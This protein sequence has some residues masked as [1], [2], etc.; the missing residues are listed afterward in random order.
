MLPDEPASIVA[1]VTSRSTPSETLSAIRAEYRDRF[2]RPEIQ[3]ALAA[4]K[5]SKQTLLRHLATSDDKA[6]RLALAK[7][8]NTP[9]D[10]LAELASDTQQG[11]RVAV[12]KNV[13]TPPDVLLVMATT[14]P[15][16]Q[17]A[18]ALA[19]NAS[20]ASTRDGQAALEDLTTDI[21]ARKPPKRASVKDRVESIFSSPHTPE[22]LNTFRS[23]G[24]A[25]VRWAAVIRGYELEIYPIAEVAELIRTTP[26]A[27]PLLEERWRETGD[28]RIADA[29]IEA[30][31]DETLAIAIK[32]GV[33]NDPI[34]LEAIVL[35]RLV[36]ACWAIATTVELDEHLL[37]HLAAVPSYSWE[38]WDP[39]SPE[40]LRPGMVF[41]PI[42]NASYPL[43]HVACHT[44]AI[45]ASHPLTP[46][47]VLERLVKARSRHVRVALAQRPYE[48]GLERLAR[49]KEPEVRAAVAVSTGLT[50]E[51]R[52][53]LQ[54]DPDPLVQSALGGS[55]APGV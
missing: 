1:L 30:G 25:N 31:S 53:L 9:G 8:R 42:A 38:V 36:A 43:G 48:A 10:V 12:A 50:P 29:M 14:E 51:L 2:D 16:A 26:Q 5:T 6:V 18:A 21:A 54:S 33:I 3:A 44:Q 39:V 15:T 47:D 55:C 32:N 40:S 17:V 24:S 7:N 22:E 11:I 35:A 4:H 45:V 28:P 41:T 23:D 19:G 13:S 46:P 49:D 34:Q 52:T 20:L 37:R 27:R